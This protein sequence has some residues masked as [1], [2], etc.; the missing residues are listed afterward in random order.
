VTVLD[1][2]AVAIARARAPGLAHLFYGATLF[3]SAGL[4]FCVE[5]MFSKMVL[6]VLGGSSSVWSVAMVVFQGL[7]LLGYVYA[8]VLT[9]ICSLRKAAL[10]HMVLMALAT[11]SLPIA[12]AP[13]FETAPPQHFVSLWL[14]GLFAVSIGLPCFA[15]SA[16]A[17]LLQAWFA[18][19]GH[20]DASNPYFLY[21]ASNFGSFAVL[22]AYPFLIEPHFGLSAQSR[23]W[24]LFYAALLASAGTC[25]F[26]ASRWQDAK[27]TARPVVRSGRV[28]ATTRLLW[29]ALGF[30]P[31]G[32]QVAITAHITTDVAS[33]PFLWILPL[34]LYL[35]T[36]V[37]LFSE[38]PAISERAVL[39]L[40]PASI[41]V[42]AVLLLWM[43]K[44]SWGVALIGHLFAFFVAAMVCHARLYRL[45]PAATDLTT[46]YALLSLGGVL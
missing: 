7:L 32:L 16:N 45:R 20:A 24:T 6:P 42:L 3:L 12:I 8:H 14:I 29:V 27:S 34:A 28:A 19:S 36:F 37:L 43:A 44:M 23:L 4:L 38:R 1:T 21:R 22:L 25:A 9:R 11:L 35:L 2:Q 10:V 33:G 15:L 31:S 41:A 17:P 18:R 46:F 39:L 5:P 40:Q 26:W 13:A 30:I